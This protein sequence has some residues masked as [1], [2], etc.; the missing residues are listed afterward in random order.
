MPNYNRIAWIYDRLAKVVFGRKQQLA[1]KAFLTNIPDN[2]KILIVG[3]GTGGILDYLQDLGRPLDV[4]FVEYSS[5]MML[6]ARKRKISNLRIYFYDQSILDLK[7][8]GYD[9]V[10]TN[11]FFDQF[12]A[13]QAY[14][15]LQHLKPKLKPKGVLIFSDFINTNHPWDRLVTK[16]M[17]SFFKLTAQIKTNRFPPYKGIFASLG[18]HPEQQKRI[19]RNI[20]ATTYTLVPPI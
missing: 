20:L 7:T 9:V 3:G 8:V 12:S 4:D 6:R 5:N 14:L 18:F 17:F 11:F 2:A 1:K 19:S 10:L 16:V 15:I 13:Y